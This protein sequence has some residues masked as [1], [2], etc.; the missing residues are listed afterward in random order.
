MPNTSNK[1]CNMVIDSKHNK[2][3]KNKY[4]NVFYASKVE[5]ADKIEKNTT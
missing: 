1:K 5:N 3:I 2:I 4:C